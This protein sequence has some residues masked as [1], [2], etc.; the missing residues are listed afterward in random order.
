LVVLEINSF[1]SGDENQ[2]GVKRNTW[3]VYT[4]MIIKI[5]TFYWMLV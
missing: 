5:V 4:L 2:G 1:R 3:F